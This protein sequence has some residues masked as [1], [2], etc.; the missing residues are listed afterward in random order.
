MKA[1]CVRF[2]PSPTGPLHIGALR[3]ALY[4]Y[5]FSKKYGGRFLLRIEDTD[6]ARALEGAAEY[7]YQTLKWMDIPPDEIKEPQS[8]RKE[9][10][11]KEAQVLREKD[12]AYY[13]FDTAEELEYMRTRLKQEHATHQHYNALTRLHMRNELTLT[14]EEVQTCL[15][16]HVPHVMRLKVSPKE[17]VSF[18]D[19]IRGRVSVHSSTLEDKILLKS[20]GMPTYHFASVVDDHYMHISH[21]IRGEEWLPSTPLHILLYRAYGWT[22]PVF[23]HLPLLLKSTGKGKLSKRDIEQSDCLL[24]PLAWQGV[25][26]FR[27]EGYLSEALFNFLVYLGWTAPKSQELLSRQEIVSAFTLEKIHKAGMR[28]D[29]KKAQWFNQQYIRQLTLAQLVDRLRAQHTDMCK[30]LS[31]TKLL[32]IVHMMQNRVTTLKEI[33][34]ATTFLHKRP[35][36]VSAPSKEEHMLLQT[37]LKHLEQRNDFADTQTLEK[38]FYLNLAKDMNL[39]VKIALKSLRYALSAAS[40][41]PDVMKILYYLGKKEAIARIKSYIYA[42]SSL[43]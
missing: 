35:T 27:E 21:V 16:Q 37:Y 43:N 34:T 18:E 25:S 12:M 42:N 14:E 32:Q 39:S 31:D 20:D 40:A 24:Y 10:Y 28:F 36:H 23:A 30:S 5:I 2:A 33:L 15:N 3:T 13:S 7:I 22:P 11:R 6:A 4:S 38:E 9:F 41:G 26:G 1:P 29:M 19:K 8:T 17:I